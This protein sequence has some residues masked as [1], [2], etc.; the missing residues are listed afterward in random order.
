VDYEGA[1]FRTRLFAHSLTIYLWTKYDTLG[2]TKVKGVLNQCV[3][4]SDEH[5]AYYS[6]TYNRIN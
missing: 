1:M 6:Y 2:G 5:K 3:Y 4:L